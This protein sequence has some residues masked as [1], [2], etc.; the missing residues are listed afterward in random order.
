M[1]DQNLYKPTKERKQLTWEEKIY[2]VVGRRQRK[3]RKEEC[4]EKQQ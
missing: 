4:Y 2:F 3:K 1:D